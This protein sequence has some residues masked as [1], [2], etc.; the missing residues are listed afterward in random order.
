MS[1]RKVKGVLSQENLTPIKLL[2]GLPK[3]SFGLPYRKLGSYSKATVVYEVNYKSKRSVLKILVKRSG[4]YVRFLNE[5]YAYKNFFRQHPAWK[6]V[7]PKV[8]AYGFDPLPYLIVEKVK[9]KST[10]DWFHY[11][12]TK[13]DFA[14]KI[15]D[16]LSIFHRAT[17]VPKKLHYSS[18][19]KFSFFLRKTKYVKQG[20]KS[21]SYE[22]AN[23]YWKSYVNNSNMADR[24]WDS[25]QDGFLYSDINPSNIFIRSNLDYKLIDFNSTSWGKLM[26]CYSFWYFNVI[27]SGVE[28]ELL[29]YI[30]KV[31]NSQKELAIFNF[32]LNYHILA[33]LY[34]FDENGDNEKMGLLISELDRLHRIGG[35]NFL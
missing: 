31:V 25:L 27:G 15:L 6:R 7:M 16:D 12:A 8:Y 14:K 26:Y 32:L 1:K 13:L 24:I 33:R 17:F 20:L 9:G 3:Y 23:K 19:H 29:D 18:Y 35:E 11:K 4:G 30:N 5:L 21:L 28:A 10:G 34:W 2:K 22:Q